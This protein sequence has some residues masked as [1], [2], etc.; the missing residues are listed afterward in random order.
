MNKDIVLF[1]VRSAI[2]DL[3]AYDKQ[4][5]SQDYDIHE[6]SVTHRLAL[7]LQKYYTDYHVDTEYNRMRKDY[8]Y[9]NES[10]LK[11]ELNWYDWGKEK[12]VLVY[13][14]INVHKRDTPDNLIIIEVKMFWKSHKKK[15]DFIKINKYMTQLGYQYG[16]YVELNKNEYSIGCG[17]FDLKSEPVLLTYQYTDLL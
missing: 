12:N 1:T 15:K 4:L 7:H 6:R 10:A 2:K 13:P 3:Y 14:D 16:L 9:L 17:E 5:L 11:K 8:Y